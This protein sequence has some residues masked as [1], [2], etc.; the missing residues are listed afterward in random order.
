L[1]GPHPEPMLNYQQR[2]RNKLIMK[3]ELTGLKR[4][5]T[6]L[7][8]LASENATVATVESTSL[9]TS[10]SFALGVNPSSTDPSKPRTLDL[11]KLPLALSCERQTIDPARSLDILQEIGEIISQWQEELKQIALDIQLVYEEGPLIDGWLESSDQSEPPNFTAPSKAERDGLMNYVEAF[12]DERVSYQTP[13]PG[14]RLCGIDDSGRVWSQDCPSD[15]VVD[16]SL[17]I[18]RY[19]KLQQLL[20]RKHNLQTRWEGIAE[21]LMMMRS[22]LDRV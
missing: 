13:R 14:Y 8:Q 17:A 1:G 22:T 9:L 12:S 19:Q 21:T 10:P 5:E 16:V 2:S 11:P 18:A 20:V 7:E 3:P 4:I 6:T 15:Q